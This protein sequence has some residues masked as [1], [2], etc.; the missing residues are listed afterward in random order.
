M[1]GPAGEDGMDG[2]QGERGFNGTQGPAGPNLISPERIYF[3]PGNLVNTSD[4]QQ[5]NTSFA[6]CDVGD[7]AIGGFSRV[8][9]LPGGTIGNIV[10]LEMGS[11]PTS[12]SW[13]TSV[14]GPLRNPIEM[15]SFAN[16]FD[17]PPPH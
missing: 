13:F 5:S 4:T 9:A 16:C 10:D 6:P 12:D 8:T 1:T 3:V 17:N 2:A 11:T 15:R 7:V 14:D